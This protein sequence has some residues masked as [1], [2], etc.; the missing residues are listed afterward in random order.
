MSA[1]ASA[2]SSMRLFQ[3][4]TN[5]VL[6]P[7]CQVGSGTVSGTVVCTAEAPLG[8]LPPSGSLLEKTFSSQVRRATRTWSPMFGPTS[9]GCS[10][11]VA[12]SCHV[13]VSTRS[14]AMVFVLPSAPV[15]CRTAACAG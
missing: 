8:V 11:T 5:R 6:E 4:G 13:S 9:T 12:S 2:R 1:P 14:K 7:P 15:H 3:C 10:V